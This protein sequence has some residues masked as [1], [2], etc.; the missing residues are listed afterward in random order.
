MIQISNIKNTKDVIKD[1]TDIK[2]KIK[3]YYE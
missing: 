3:R 1:H 2:N